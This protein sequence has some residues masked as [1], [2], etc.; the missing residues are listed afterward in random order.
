MT[1]TEA[2]FSFK[3]RLNRM[4][5]F[6]YS[7]LN[8]VIGIVG[9]CIA[10]ECLQSDNAIPLG[11]VIGVSTLVY[12]VWTGYSIAAK[13]LHDIG[14]SAN[15]LWGIAFVGL[16]T[17][18]FSSSSPALSTFFGLIQLA[19]SAALLFYRGETGTNKYGS[20]PLT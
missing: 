20:D 11:V 6:G 2:L 1:L 4:A 19:I 18:A 16:A 15:Y 3:G 10:A 17:S 5:Y 9:V 12:L 8:F 14:L 7:V 13:R